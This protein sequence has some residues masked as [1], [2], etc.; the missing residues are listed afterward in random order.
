MGGTGKTSMVISTVIRAV[1]N[2]GGRC[3][4][5][6]PTN[7]NIDVQSVSL[8]ERD[9]TS[10]RLSGQEAMDLRSRVL[11]GTVTK[12]TMSNAACLRQWMGLHIANDECQPDDEGRQSLHVSY[13]SRDAFKRI[14]KKHNIPRDNNNRVGDYG[15]DNS[16]KVWWISDDIVQTRH[17]LCV[18]LRKY[19]WLCDDTGARENGTLPYLVVVDESSMINRREF[20]ETIRVCR[21]AIDDGLRIHLVLMGDACQLLPVESGQG[22]VDL[23]EYGRDVGKHAGWFHELEKNYRLC[24][25][26]KGLENLLHAVRR[27][28]TSLDHLRGIGGGVSYVKVDDTMSALEHIRETHVAG[29]TFMAHTNAECL[30]IHATVRAIRSSIPADESRKRIL[31]QGR[32]VAVVDGKCMLLTIQRHSSDDSTMVGSEVN[33]ENEN[34]SMSIL[35]GAKLAGGM[36]RVPIEDCMHLYDIG[37]SILFNCNDPKTGVYKGKKGTITALHGRE[38]AMFTVH[39]TDG[40]AHS[41]TCTTEIKPAIAQTVHT[42]QGSQ[43]DRVVMIAMRSTQFMNNRNMFYTAVSRAKREFTLI[44][45]D[46]DEHIRQS[47]LVTTRNSIVHERLVRNSRG[48]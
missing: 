40:I 14:M 43:Y 21:T 19:R 37:D 1:L 10:I 48:V 13:H 46:P 33:D 34:A 45:D 12:A 28:E 23:V 16:R 38:K 6:S 7:K 47:H 32:A 22:F 25:D 24:D 5:L 41:V 39:D 15:F 26:T 18:D 42:A 2:K 17:E 4:I 35:C 3:M 29:V 36:V 8:A 44:T 27:S 30:R 20:R 9:I 31:D 11:L